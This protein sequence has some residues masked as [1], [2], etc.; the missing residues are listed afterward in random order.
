MKNRILLLIIVLLFNSCGIFKTHHKDKL[1][2]FE[3]NSLTNDSLKLNGYYFAEFDLD[4]GENAPPFIDDYIKKT[5]INKIKHLSVFFIYEDG[6]IVNAGGINGLSRYYCAEKENY[7]NTYDSAHKTIELM[8]E[9]QNSIEKR[10]KRL[11]SFNPNDIGSKGLIQINKEKIKIQLY[12][13]EM[14]KPT[15]DSFNSA[16]L[17]EL[18]GTIKSD[19]SFVI[20]SEKE[21][22][23]KDITPKNQVFEFKQIAQKPNVENYF[24]KNKNRF[25]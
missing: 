21:F 7:A 19:S 13:I 24:K 6:F 11:C 17:Y 1:I 5:G 14:Q 18:N 22:R 3:N 2:D 25:K 9:S 10:T 12:R 4:Y 20:N 16:Y 23:T 15:K 8:L